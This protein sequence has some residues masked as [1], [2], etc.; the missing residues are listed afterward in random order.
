MTSSSD[1][2]LPRNLITRSDRFIYW[3]SHH[4]LAVFNVITAIYV[5]LPF[6]APVLMHAGLTG[7]AQ[8][9]YTVYYPLCHQFPYRSW[10]LFGA[11]PNYERPQFEQLT[12][13]NTLSLPG[14]LE[15]KEFKGNEQMGYKVAFCERDVAI[16]GGL[17]AGALIFGFVR[18]RARP[19]PWWLW[20]ILGVGPIALDGFS[21]LFSQ[22]PTLFGAYNPLW[23]PDNPYWRES[24]PLLRTLT[25]GLFGFMLVWLAYPYIED[26]MLDTRAQLQRR[27]GWKG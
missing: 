23:H 11:Q 3:F 12:G 27:F 22:L 16:Y 17:L 9:I 1:A 24:T 6:M 26:A 15:A 19:M 8:A 10:F 7:P 13:I 21:Q 20:A 4:W 14:Q 2:S 25:G 5:G 18:Q